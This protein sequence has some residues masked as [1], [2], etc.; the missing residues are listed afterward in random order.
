MTKPNHTQVAN[1]FIDVHMRNLSGPAV[2]VCLVIFR[3]TIGWH[4]DTVPVSISQLVELTGL[5]NRL[6]IK[7][8][9]ELLQVGLITA[10]R[11]PGRTTVY[12][13]AYDESEPATHD[14]SSWVPMTERHT[15]NKESK[16][17]EKK[18]REEHAP[19]PSAALSHE[20]AQLPHSAP[21]SLS[22]LMLRIRKE[23]QIRGAPPT[24]ISRDW[25]VRFAELLRG[26][27]TEEELLQAFTVCI[28][29]APER[30]T[31][32]PRDFL[33]WRKAWRKSVEK[34]SAGVTFFFPEAG[35]SSRR[36]ARADHCGAG[37]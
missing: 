5:S 23:A 3:K 33:R 24:F 35:P 11:S 18:K 1:D 19:Q 2:K 16:K 17:P 27:I 12:G 30:V 7:S 34:R 10:E 21:Q 4:K 28:E 29:T 25:S 9:R 20:P 13:I 32:F 31:F 8:I 6:V 37:E 14:E 26:G 15:Q 36:G 22:P